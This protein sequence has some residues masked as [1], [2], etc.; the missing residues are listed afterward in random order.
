MVSF[1]KGKGMMV[2]LTPYLSTIQWPARVSFFG[3]HA[4]LATLEMAPPQQASHRVF[5]LH[6]TAAAAEK[7]AL[8]RAMK[9]RVSRALW[10]KK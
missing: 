8:L 6:F 4:M 10:K 5:L 1:G 9:L 7:V 3:L 2:G